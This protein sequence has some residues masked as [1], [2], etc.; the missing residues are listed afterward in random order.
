MHADDE[1]QH[2]V[3]DQEDVLMQVSSS[4]SGPAHVLIENESTDPP[5]NILSCLPHNTNNNHYATRHTIIPLIIRPWTDT[6]NPLNPR[7]TIS[8]W[9][10]YGI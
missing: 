9:T 4:C 10:I 5:S 7:W 8:K 2:Q 3:Q 1:Q 6:P